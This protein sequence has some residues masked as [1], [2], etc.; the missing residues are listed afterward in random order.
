MSVEFHNLTVSNVNKET[1]DAVSVS[2][3]VPNELREVFHYTQGQ[4]LTLKFEIGGKEER[5]A[6]SMSSSPLEPDLTISVKRVA[7]GKVSNHLCS[8][9]KVGDTVAVM[10]PQGRFH[11]PLSIEQRKTYYLFSAGSGITPLMSILKTILESE[12]AS[13]VHLLYGN[14][15]EDS[16]IFKQQ[17]ADLVKKY[18]GQLTVEHVLT[19]PKKE[20]SGGL[21]GLFSKGKITWEGK[22]GRIDKTTIEAFLNQNPAR[23]K[24][25][26]YFICGPGGMID[27]VHHT[28]Q[29]LN[30][31]KKY[32]H[33][34]HFAN[35]SP[36]EPKATG[37]VVEGAKLTVYLNSVQIEAVMKPKD[38][39]L[40]TLIALKKEPPY[41][42]TSGACSTC[43]AKVL[44]GSVKMAACYALDDDEVANGYILTCQ[45]YATSPEVEITYDL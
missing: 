39:I 11:T 32:I 3:S 40:D 18:A 31:D 8:N 41:S 26:E 21:S 10:S 6:Y 22:V 37:A 24:V 29:A 28:L 1:E 30:V 44:K 42:C 19:Q 34:E 23:T 17:L 14:R 33:I 12:P 15:S 20:K 36:A 2:F 9:V 25:S 35:D 13:V 16:I 38:T 45:S 43:M 5:R 4:Y 7:K 27:A